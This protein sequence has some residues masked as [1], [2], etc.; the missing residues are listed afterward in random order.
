MLVS[1]LTVLQDST[2]YLKHLSDKELQYLYK[3]GLSPRD[4][5][6]KTIILHH[7]EQNVA[8]PIIEMLDMWKN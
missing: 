5:N 7:H 8:G 2:I 1:S 6:G 4:I 3:K